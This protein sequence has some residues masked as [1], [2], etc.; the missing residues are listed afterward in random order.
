MGE[1][2]FGFAFDHVYSMK[3][4][5]SQVGGG[6]GVG[7]FGVRMR[8]KGIPKCPQNDMVPHRMFFYTAK[9]II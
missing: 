6:S 7:R 5:H 1:K 8:D 3:R 9:K 2:I 4:W